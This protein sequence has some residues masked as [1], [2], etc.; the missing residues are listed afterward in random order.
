M[1][2]GIKKRNITVLYVKMKAS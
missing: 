2:E 1:A